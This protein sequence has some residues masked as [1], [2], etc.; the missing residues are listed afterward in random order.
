MKDHKVR[1]G[2][3]VVALANLSYFLW[4]AMTNTPTY[5][6]SKLLTPIVILSAVVLQG[7]KSS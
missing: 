7:R 3:I 1:S 4:C 5:S 2:L 6:I